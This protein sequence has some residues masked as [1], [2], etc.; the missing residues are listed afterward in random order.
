MSWLERLTGGFKKTADRLGE[1][2]SGLVK[3][4][5]LDT[6]TLDAPG[7]GALRLRLVGTRGRDESM[8]LRGDDGKGLDTWPQLQVAASANADSVEAVLGGSG[9]TAAALFA[10]LKSGTL[11]A[12][13]LPGTLT[14]EAAGYR[15]QPRLGAAIFMFIVVAIL[16]IGIV[17]MALDLMFARLQKAVTYAD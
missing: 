15:M 13:D 14:L 6:A 12:F 10:A 1:N 2:L 11:Q 16:V 9:R 8:T 5:A 3:E 7:V 4:A 17:G